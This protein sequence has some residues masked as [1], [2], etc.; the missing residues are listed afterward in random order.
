MLIDPHGQTEKRIE[1]SE[2]KWRA[3][4]NESQPIEHAL[5]RLNNN[6]QTTINKDTERIGK[7]INRHTITSTK[8][9]GLLSE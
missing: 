8:Q 7:E 2:T 4:K 9:L 5:E 6:I 1:V 3:E